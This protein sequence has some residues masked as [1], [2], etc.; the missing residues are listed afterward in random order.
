MKFSLAS[1]KKIQPIYWIIV[2]LFIVVL[3][4]S[5]YAGSYVP[6]RKMNIFSHE[7]P[8][9]GFISDYPENIHE[10]LPMNIPEVKKDTSGVL[11][12]FNSLQGA[13]IPNG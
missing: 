1:L 12:F 6:Y 2:G 11:G 13:P 10:A 5:N 8:Y 3:V 7:Y 9:E 4:M